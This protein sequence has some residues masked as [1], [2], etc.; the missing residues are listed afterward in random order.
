MWLYW[1]IYYTFGPLI[2]FLFQIKVEGKENLAPTGAYILA[3]N[4]RSNIDFMAVGFNVHRHIHFFGKSEILEYPV[5]GYIMKSVQSIPV[6]R[7]EHD[8]E[9]VERAVGYL[10]EGEVFFI[11]PEGTRS[12]D[13]RFL[14]FHTGVARI[15]LMSGAP[16][17]PI[18]LVGTAE[19][20]S[21][22]QYIPKFFKSCAVCF[23][24]PID[25]SQRYAG[26]ENDYEKL[27]E[28]TAKIREEIARMMHEYE[29]ETGKYYVQENLLRLDIK[30]V[31]AVDSY[32]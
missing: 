14:R 6:R 23:G 9:A 2:R 13:G 18:A 7:G 22:H 24:K 19:I 29:I 12:L 4:H 30:G 21:K 17:I 16:V 8:V 31:F 1:L 11:A 20:L 28:I 15:A 10:K 27:T 32:R 5:I 26:Y 3:A 25:F